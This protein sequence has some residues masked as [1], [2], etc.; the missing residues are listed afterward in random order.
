MPREAG[1]CPLCGILLSRYDAYYL[2]QHG[3][4]NHSGHELHPNAHTCSV[5]TQYF[6]QNSESRLIIDHY[7]TQHLR[8]YAS[9]QVEQ[10]RNADMAPDEAHDFNPNMINEQ[11]ILNENAY[12]RNL[13]NDEEMAHHEIIP[14]DDNESSS[15]GSSSDADSSINDTLSIESEIS[16]YQEELVNGLNHEPADQVVELSP[17][18]IRELKLVE[19]CISVGFSESDYKLFWKGSPEKIG[20]IYITLL[21]AILIAKICLIKS[22]CCTGS[23]LDS[24]DDPIDFRTLKKQLDRLSPFSGAR[25][26]PEFIPEKLHLYSPKEC[27]T[28]WVKSAPMRESL[29]EYN[30]KFTL[31]FIQDIDRSSA[32]R[33][34]QMQEPDY[35]FTGFSSGSEWL[36]VLRRTK[37]FWRPRIRVDDLQ[38]STSCIP[39]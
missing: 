15:R 12:M 25:I 31:P 24:T 21:I 4:R 17:Q 11:G 23:G 34:E 26:L 8:K 39:L 28:L 14:S 3:S 35:Q 27:V 2:T 29:I 36:D 6:P 37:Q 38:K 9:R 1:L 18:S 7:C 30:R 20:V 10:I 16:N 22:N 13:P 33:H 5:C 32:L 19:M